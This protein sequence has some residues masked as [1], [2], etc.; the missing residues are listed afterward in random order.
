MIIVSNDQLTTHI[1]KGVI[2]ASVESNRIL[3]FVDFGVQKVI[4]AVGAE[5]VTALETKRAAQTLAGKYQELFTYMERTVSWYAYSKYLPFSS[6]TDGDNGLQETSSENTQPTRIGI[7]DR[8]QRAC[9]EN[10]ANSFEAM[11]VYLFAN[12]A[13]FAE[14]NGTPA[15]EAYNSLIV[16]NA[17]ELTAALP[18]VNGQYKMF[19][20]LKGWIA[21]E[22]EELEKVTGKTL[23]TAIMAKLKDDSLKNS[24]FYLKAW[25]YAAR[26]VCKKAFHNAL[27]E[28]QVVQTGNGL[29]V[30]SEFDGINNQKAPTPEQ[31][32]LLEMSLRDKYDEAFGDLVTYLSENEAELPGFK[33]EGAYRETVEPR[34]M[35]KYDNLVG[36]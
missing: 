17:T 24:E 8:R 27:P 5:L 16:R 33:E 3:A 12:S 36:L 26:Y 1:G 28:L 13:D 34:F 18:S 35:T 19:V 11:M 22:Q 29:R 30:L 9:D 25:K 6:G 31:Y 10:A 32:S 15:F 4:K 14:W 23:L 2:S 21:E 7:L 20:S